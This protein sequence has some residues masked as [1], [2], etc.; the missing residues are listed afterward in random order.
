M[1][2]DL[3]GAKAVWRLFHKKSNPRELIDVTIPWPTDWEYAGEAVTTYYKSD[4]WT[5]DNKLV[6]YY[7]DHNEK[8]TGKVSLFHPKGLFAWTAK[9]PKPRIRS[10]PTAVAVLGHA[11]GVDVRRH[12]TGKLVHASPEKAAYLVSSPNKKVLW[13]VEPRSGITAMIIGSGLHVEARG[14]VG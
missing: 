5:K 4:K 3:A 7:H 6:R 12:D 9:T 13:I 1:S 10:Y 2:R 14:I 11:L 8:G